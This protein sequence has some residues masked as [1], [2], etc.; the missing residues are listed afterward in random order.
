MDVKHATAALQQSLGQAH[1]DPEQGRQGDFDHWQRIFAASDR[2]SVA[3][4]D[5]SHSGSDAYR[6]D[7][8]AHGPRHP[9]DGGRLRAHAQ[10]GASFAWQGDANSA[11]TSSTV[12]AMPHEPG[13]Q[14]A[15]VSTHQPLGMRTLVSV[16]QQLPASPKGTAESPLRPGGLPTPPDGRPLAQLQAHLNR[17][18]EGRLDVALRSSLPLSTS[19]A[20]HAVAR[21]L[22]EQGSDTPVGQVLLNGQPIY[23]AVTSSTHRFEI[24][25]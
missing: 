5:A 20:L 2:R 7:L 16:N 21:A 22:S 23:R 8:P 25:C 10:L 9:N 11:S 15:L 19:Q 14:R 13:A 3:A 4:V 24:D 12:A 1:V 17:N 18:A 6:V